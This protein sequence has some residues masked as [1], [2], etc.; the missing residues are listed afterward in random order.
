MF[1]DGSDRMYHVVCNTEGQYSL[2][3]TDRAIPFG[4]APTGT[5]GAKTACLSHIT[6]VWTDLRPRGAREGAGR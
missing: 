2:W 4:W 1:E 5:T 3:P 6:A